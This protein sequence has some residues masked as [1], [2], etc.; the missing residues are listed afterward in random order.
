MAGAPATVRYTAQAMG[1]EYD[2]KEE[3][4]TQVLVEA[5]D[6]EPSPSP[7]PS[8]SSL[9]Q[10]QWQ[11]LAEPDFKSES[12]SKEW[13]HGEAMFPT[14]TV[15]SPTWCCLFLQSAWIHALSQSQD[16]GDSPDEYKQVW[17]HSKISTISERMNQRN[18]EVH[19]RIMSPGY[20]PPCGA[21]AVWVFASETQQR[22]W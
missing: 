4:P 6:A 8:P 9:T 22:E 7:K 20:M 1:G 17:L 18:L 2:P 5:I 14:Y 12:A 3:Q 19:V 11:M 13:W 16:D 10:E 21:F 15:L